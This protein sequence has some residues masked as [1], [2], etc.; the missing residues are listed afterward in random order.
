MMYR[1]IQAKLHSTWYRRLAARLL[2]R[3]DRIVHDPDIPEAILAR[4]R[5]D[6]VRIAANGG[7]G[8]DLS[9]LTLIMKWGD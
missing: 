5:A 2:G 3:A 1:D 4:A 7:V 6:A 8:Q 9:G